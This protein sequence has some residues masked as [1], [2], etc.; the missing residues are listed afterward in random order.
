MLG[1]LVSAGSSLL[2][3]FMASK[4]ADKADRR[5]IEFAKNGIR[6]KVEDAKRA[7]VHPIYALGANTVSYSPTQAGDMGIA[8]AG[9][10]IGRAIDT[11]LSQPERNSRIAQRSAELQLQNME[12][13]NTK[14]AS[15]IRLTN[16]AGSPPSPITENPIIPG[17]GVTDHKASI[18]TSTEVGVP[19]VEATPT[20]YMKWSWT[21][22]GEIAPLPAKEVQE[23][24][25]SNIFSKL[26]YG[27]NAHMMPMLGQG[28]P[29]SNK[30]LPP[31][32]THFKFNPVTQA[33]R[34]VFPRKE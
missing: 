7:G 11:S 28:V 9:Q 14:L 20:P 32:A 30:H 27:A 15:E 18:Q 29:P 21:P 22:Y 13:Q 23:A 1:A 24:I 5:Q 25:E 31:G 17:Q 3:G 8:Q 33:W 4:Q 10:D 2:G 19:W 26:A 12:L 16:Q 6:W 34:P